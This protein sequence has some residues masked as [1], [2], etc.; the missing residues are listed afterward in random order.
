MRGNCT[1]FKSHLVLLKVLN[2]DRAVQDREDDGH[3]SATVFA[4]QAAALCHQGRGHRVFFRFFPRNGLGALEGHS[5]K[6]KINSVS[7]AFKYLPLLLGS[8]DVW[9]SPM[10]ETLHAQTTTQPG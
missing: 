9:L 3:F 5:S 6:V 4:A 10:Q 8:R 7:L 2:K 1:T